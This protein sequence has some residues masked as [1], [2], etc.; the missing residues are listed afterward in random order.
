M[1]PNF[2]EKYA[3][4]LFQSGKFNLSFD[5]FSLFIDYDNNISKRVLE[6]G[7][8]FYPDFGLEPGQLGILGIEAY[9]KVC[10]IKHKTDDALVL[11]LKIVNL[12]Q[13]CEYSKSII[14]AMLY[15]YELLIS[16]EEDDEVKNYLQNKRQE[17][18]KK[19][20]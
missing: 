20:Y 13:N 3:F 5:L 18:L 16:H 11:A 1:E 2:P 19:K 8:I 10:G 15:S 12:D 6:N 4:A 9:A 7:K 14:K 17:I